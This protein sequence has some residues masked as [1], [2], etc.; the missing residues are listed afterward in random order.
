[1]VFDLDTY[2]CIGAVPNTGLHGVAVDPK[3]HHG[4][5]STSPVS[6][7]DT[8]T[9]EPIKKITVEGSPDGILFE[10]ATER[11]YVLSHRAPNVTV[12]K[13]DDGTVVGTIDL[14]GQPEQ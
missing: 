12:I 3:T 13:P 14:G 6:M 4:F 10:P 7:F 2:K 11:I 9:L 8:T 1:M 5:V